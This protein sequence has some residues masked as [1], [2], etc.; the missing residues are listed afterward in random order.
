MTRKTSTRMGKKTITIKIWYAMDSP[1]SKSGVTPGGG[2]HAAT[3]EMLPSAKL[4]VWAG[5]AEPETGAGP[6]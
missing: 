3:V 4:M 6:S 5:G 1:F 2:G